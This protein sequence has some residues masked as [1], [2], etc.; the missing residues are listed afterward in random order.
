MIGKEVENK[1]WIELD[2][3]FVMYTRG[4]FEG[5]RAGVDDRK[6]G[7][8]WCLNGGSAEENRGM[9]Q[10]DVSERQVDGSE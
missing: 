3:I 10:E 9:E 6:K 1:L 4:V 7:Q 5:K 8:S 2:L